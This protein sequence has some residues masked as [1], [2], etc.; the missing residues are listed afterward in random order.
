M[1]ADLVLLVIA[2]LVASA[3]F[4]GIEIA[5]LSSNKLQIELHGKQGLLSG[6]IFSYFTKKTSY[7]IGT[8]LV[9]NTISLVLYGI[10][11]AQLIE[12]KLREY[13][14]EAINTEASVLISQTLLSTIVVLFTAEFLP[15][16][17][18]LINPNCNSS[19][20]SII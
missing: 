18:F 8:T 10:L 9:G 17:L 2:T 19:R 20:M 7:F 11:M 12:P 14:P 15:K 4:S 6:K 3:F 16:S 1:D 13:L 5:Y